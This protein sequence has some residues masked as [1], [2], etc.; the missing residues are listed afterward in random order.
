M[1]ATILLLLY[2]LLLSGKRSRSLV[3]F[4]PAITQNGQMVNVYIY[5]SNTRL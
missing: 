4:L 5:Q 3:K 1:P 2:T